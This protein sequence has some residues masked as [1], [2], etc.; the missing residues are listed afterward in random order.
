[1]VLRTSKV[2]AK[3]NLLSLFELHLWISR[4]DTRKK[5]QR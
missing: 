2:T 3:K 4:M 1:L 5:D